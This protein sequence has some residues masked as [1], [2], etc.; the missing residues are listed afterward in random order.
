MTLRTASIVI[1]LLGLG[2]SL[3]LAV[4][5]LSG[6]APVCVASHGCEVV[7]NSR[8]ARLSGVPVPLLGIAGYGLLL[9][10]TL[11]R[12]ELAQML[13][14]GVA[15]A[16]FGFSMYLTWLEL[17]VIHAICQWCVVSAVLMTAA[18]VVWVLRIRLLLRSAPPAAN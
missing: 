11:V 9:V 6:G 10:L 15:L 16:G 5:Y 7:Q 2:V 13:A 4:V 3:Y 8:Y 14:L 17:A 1:S 12:G 18:L